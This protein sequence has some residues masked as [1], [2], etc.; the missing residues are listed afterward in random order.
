MGVTGDGV[1]VARVGV[2]V[3]SAVGSTTVIKRC[4]R[5]VPPAD[6]FGF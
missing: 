5:L 4:A 3:G 2:A 6:G 1:P